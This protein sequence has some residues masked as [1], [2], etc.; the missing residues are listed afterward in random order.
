MTLI[1]SEETQAVNWFKNAADHLSRSLTLVEKDLTSGKRTPEATIGII[2][3]LI[4]KSKGSLLT[5]GSRTD[6]DK[7]SIKLISSKDKGILSD[8]EIDH[9]G[10]IVGSSDKMQSL[11][12]LCKKSASCDATVLIN[13]ETGTGKELIAKT[14][15]SMSSRSDEPFITIDCGSIPNELIESELFGHEKGAFS[16]AQNQRKGAFERAHKGTVFLDEIGELPKEMQPKLLRILEE[17]KFKR[18]GGDSYISTDIRVIA[19]T[20]RELNIEVAKGN[21]REDLFFR[22]YVIP[23]SLP[24]LRERK[25]DIPLLVNHFINKNTLFSGNE[26]QITI[27]DDALNKM[28]DYS[29][30]GNVRELR[31]VIDRAIVNSDVQNITI[32]DIQFIPNIHS[33]TGPSPALSGSLEDIEKQTILHALKA[34]SGNKKATAKVL[35]IAYSTMCDKVKKYKIEV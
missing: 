3:S 6:I 8:N 5:P 7:A 11:Y 33:D 30:P 35:G 34:R 12:N 32:D 13:G 2:S 19:A 9:L 29:W 1:R 17:R 15:H 31:N 23:V 18:V 28:A 27:S 14:I 21:F 25:G 26:S 24:S 16:G 22:L 10:E 20:N 4:L